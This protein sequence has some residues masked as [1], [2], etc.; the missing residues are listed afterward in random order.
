[1]RNATAP[2]PISATSAPNPGVVVGVAVGT[3][4]G[5]VVLTTVVGG[6][7]VGTVVGTNSTTVNSVVPVTSLAVS[8]PIAETWDD[9]LI[10]L[11]G[12]SVNR[13]GPCVEA[14]GSLDNLHGA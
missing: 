10:G 6:T 12:S 5:T 9:V 8:R 7:V 3:V 11:E 4:V 13:E 1:M 14:L 2:S